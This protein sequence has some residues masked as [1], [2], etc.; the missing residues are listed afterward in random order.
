M[1]SVPIPL[2]IIRQDVNI[3]T[4]NG[5]FM[6]ETSNNVIITPSANLE[7]K[8]I[9]LIVAHSTNTSVLDTWLVVF[10]TVPS[11]LIFFHSHLLM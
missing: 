11:I 2:K 7:L 9:D 1:T 3:L 10:S 6:I 5:S 8:S 4:T